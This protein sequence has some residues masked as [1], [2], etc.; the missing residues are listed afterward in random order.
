MITNSDA[1]DD[2]PTQEIIPYIQKAQQKS[3][4]YTKLIIGDS[5]CHQIFNGFQNENKDYAT[6]GSNQAITIVG[7]YL[8]AQE[9][10]RNHSDTTDV[11]LIL[12]SMTGSGFSNAGYCYQ[13]FVIPFS[14]MNVIEKIDPETKVGLSNIFGVFYT[15]RNFIELIDH[16]NICRKL[17]LNSLSDNGYADEAQS[18][19]YLKKLV[20]LCNE[21]GIELHLL[22]APMEESTKSAVENEMN[23]EIGACQDS[24]ILPYVKEYYDSVTFYPDSYFKD[25]IHFKDEYSSKKQL[26]YY[27]RN[28]QKNNE[29]QGFCV[30]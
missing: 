21:N 4:G 19:L 6:I 25:G 11:Y 8:L 7:Q 27:I 29:L 10:V 30:K 24:E 12:T 5:V 3:N 28:M 13:Y 22:H 14:E 26:I 1:Y 17:Y 2:G 9:F 16:S 20:D 15:N 18:Y 23:K